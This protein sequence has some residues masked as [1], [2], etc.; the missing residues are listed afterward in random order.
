MAAQLRGC[1][2][3]LRTKLA[4]LTSSLAGLRPLRNAALPACLLRPLSVLDFWTGVGHWC[5]GGTVSR[6][7][8]MIGVNSSLVDGADGLDD[9]R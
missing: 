1:P 2:S 3:S 8:Y 7:G 9:S 5:S 6:C 4:W